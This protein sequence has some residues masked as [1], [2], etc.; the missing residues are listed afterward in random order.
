MKKLYVSQS[1]HYRLSKRK[2]TTS[3]I[4]IV[5]ICQE[6]Q[7]IIIN[8]S[9]T[10]SQLCLLHYCDKIL[11]NGQTF[12]LIIS[13]ISWTVQITLYRS[14]WTVNKRFWHAKSITENTFEIAYP[15]ALRLYWK[16]QIGPPLKLTISDAFFTSLGVCL[17]SDVDFDHMKAVYCK[18]GYYRRRAHKR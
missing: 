13:N 9:L 10:R 3:W 14:F 18:Y 11:G 12:V 6:L 8:P 4:A 5:M 15:K 2:V 17:K 16:T 1:L 7:I